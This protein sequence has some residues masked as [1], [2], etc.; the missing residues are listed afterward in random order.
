ME[1]INTQIS[2]IDFYSELQETLNT[3]KWSYD[4]SLPSYFRKNTYLELV[5]NKA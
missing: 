3:N 5:M 1:G 4:Y 2:D